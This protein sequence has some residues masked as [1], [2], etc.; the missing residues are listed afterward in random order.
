MPGRGT[1]TA[2]LGPFSLVEPPIGST[3]YRIHSVPCLVNGMP[4]VFLVLSVYSVRR[5]M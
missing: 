1:F 3:V 2:S 4:G 5:T